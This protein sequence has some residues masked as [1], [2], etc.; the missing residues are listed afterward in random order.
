LYTAHPSMAQRLDNP[1]YYLNNFEFVLNWLEQR[2]ADVLDSNEQCFLQQYRGLPRASR[3]L[4]V[5]MVM[6]RGVLFRHSRLHYAEIGAVGPALA[7]LVQAGW[8]DANPL[9]NL[10]QLFGLFPKAELLRAFSR[11]ALP[12]TLSKAALYARLSEA[13]SACADATPAPC[14]SGA[15]AALPTRSPGSNPPVLPAR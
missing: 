1:F 9:L 2:Y 11:H 4:L 3:A 13:L 10:E 8:V 5:R 14:V 12:P 6:R 7:P 15:P